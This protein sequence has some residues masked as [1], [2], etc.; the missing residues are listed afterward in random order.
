MVKK[1]HTIAMRG[2]ETHFHTQTWH[3]ISF[4]LGHRK[5]HASFIH[6]IAIVA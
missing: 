5:T 2:D 6:A 1:L 3:E 4:M